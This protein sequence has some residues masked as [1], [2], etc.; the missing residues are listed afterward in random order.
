MILEAAAFVSLAVVAAVVVA[1]VS[2]LGGLGGLLYGLVLM[3]FNPEEFKKYH[4]D[5]KKG[6]N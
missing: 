4:P 3:V 6:L 2:V 1:V 5:Y